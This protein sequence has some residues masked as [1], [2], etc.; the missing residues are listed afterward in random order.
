MFNPWFIVGALLSLFLAFG[1]GHHQGYK[2]GSNEQKVADQNAVDAANNR[3]QGIID[4][5]NKQISEQKAVASSK[6]KA[7][8][9]QVIAAQVERDQFKA[10]LG[11]EHVRNQTI[12][13]RLSDV[14]AAYSLRF[15]PDVGSGC[16]GSAGSGE[17]AKDGAS[18]NALPAAIQLPEAITRDLRQLVEDA[19]ELNDDYKLCY[20]Y[21]NGRS[22]AAE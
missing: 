4:G 21:A 22:V 2:S 7:Q 10:K 3:T 16:G 13:R 15:K 6:E 20:G 18:S 8:R 5:Y 14:Y 19:D 1:T 12:T 11:V 9:D 17:A